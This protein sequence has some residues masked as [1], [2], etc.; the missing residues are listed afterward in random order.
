M[1]EDCAGSL[2]PAQWV[3]PVEP[4]TS[5]AKGWRGQEVLSYLRR[6]ILNNRRH[7]H[8]LVA[9]VVIAIVV[10]YASTQP[11]PGLR[12]VAVVLPRLVELVS[13]L[14]G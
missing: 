10:L 1:P 9:I 3:S 4:P 5:P 8:D 2:S 7:D 13:A 11:L 14:M 12:D 6:H